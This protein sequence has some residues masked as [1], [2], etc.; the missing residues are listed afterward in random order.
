MMMKEM[1]RR[2]WKNL[3]E[4]ELIPELIAGAQAREVAM[5]AQGSDPFKLAPP[6]SLVEIAEGIGRC[7]VCPIGCNGTRA[8]AG[9]GPSRAP[10]MIVGE[11]PGDIE[12]REGRPFVG[13]AG[14]L[15][16]EYLAQAEVDQSQARLT[17]AVKH[18]KF[19]QRGKR[20][21]HQNP[22]AGE[23]DRCRWWLD[24]ERRLVQPSIILAM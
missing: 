17:N 20:R 7:T 18:F 1:P 2:Y 14:Q 15:L 3:P 10:L 16:R 11:Q 19:E 9:E 21:I 12:E 13:P 8:V 4:A 5:I 6:A 24:A 22:S 23:I